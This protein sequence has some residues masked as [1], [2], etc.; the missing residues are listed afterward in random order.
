M[1]PG[2]KEP[3]KV[4]VQSLVTFLTAWVRSKSTDILSYKYCMQD[5]NSQI[6][7]EEEQEEV[8]SPIAGKE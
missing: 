7:G 5:I 8:I 3:K 6:S 4:F 1:L 2:M